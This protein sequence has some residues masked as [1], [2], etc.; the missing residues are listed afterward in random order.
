MQVTGTRIQV[1]GNYTTSNPVT[2]ITGEDLRRLGV[3]NVS[4]ALTTLVPQNIS[5]YQP[6]MTGNG[7]NG[8]FFVG[9]TI[10]NLRGLDPSFGSRTLT[11]IDGRRVVSTSN[12]ADVVDLNIIPSNL[13][14]RMDVVTGGAS[15][16]YGSGAMAG[17]VNPRAEQ[18]PAGREP[19]CGLWRHRG[20]RRRQQ[21]HRAVG[22]HRAVR[23]AA[24]TSCLAANGR[25]RTPSAAAPRRATGARNRARC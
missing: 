6:T 18:P 8:S 12:Q 5:L 20:R 1:P 15:A 17:V 14:S 11:M 24:A 23:A 4:D 10:A 9:A 25:T 21:A 3:V 22:R 7:A 2:T 19:G 16:A 13:L